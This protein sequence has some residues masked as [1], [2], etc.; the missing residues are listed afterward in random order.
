MQALAC[1]MIV[2]LL[3]WFPLIACSGSSDERALRALKKMQAS[4]FFEN[5]AQQ[6]LAKAIEK[7]D[8][9]Q[10]NKALERG[11]DV[12]AVGRDGM[13]PL[14]WAIS[15]QNIDGFRFLLE[16]GADPNIVV[17]L[18]DGFQESEAGAMEMAARM[19]DSR[20]LRLL[21]EHGGNPNTIIDSE[22][23]IPL[24]YRAIMSRQSDNVTLL[25]EFG[26]DI[27]HQD[28]A[29]ETPLMQAATARIFGIALLLLRQGADPTIKNQ[30]GNAPAYIVKQFGNR[31][32]DTRTDDLSAYYEF[33]EELR[34]RGLLD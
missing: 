20:Y 2:A 17:E 12:N 24:L 33:V 9:V 26:A 6:L 16:H 21:L 13:T 5:S 10:L 25:V 8:L 18:P 30:W 32:I 15:K 23:Q 31:G 22:G 4:D 1:K 28:R 27:D 7:G 3:V 14:F 34:K 29:G 11:A 19:K